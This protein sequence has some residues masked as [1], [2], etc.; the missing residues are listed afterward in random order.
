MTTNL[1]RGNDANLQDLYMDFMRETHDLTPAVG[2]VTGFLSQYGTP[3]EKLDKNAKVARRVEMMFKDGKTAVV[4]HPD[5]NKSVAALTN[6]GA[7]GIRERNR[8][9]MAFTF[10]MLVSRAEIDYRDKKDSGSSYTYLDEMVDLF[11][12]ALEVLKEDQE[13]LFSNGFDG[14]IMFAAAE[15]GAAIAAGATGDLSVAD[16]AIAPQNRLLE[17]VRGGTLVADVQIVTVASPGGAGPAVIQIKNIGTASYTPAQGDE[18]RHLNQGIDGSLFH[19]LDQAFD[20]AAYP[21]EQG[22]NIP[23]SSTNNFPNILSGGNA[24]VNVAQMEKMEMD[25]TRRMNKPRFDRID[26]NRVGLPAGF[27]YIYVGRD[28]MIH[29]LANEFRQAYGRSNATDSSTEL[30]PA[31]VVLIDGKP[32]LKAKTLRNDRFYAL[33]PRD[34]ASLNEV[35]QLLNPNQDRGF[36][37]VPQ[38]V[39]S[40]VIMA[41]H[42]GHFCINRPNQA[43][44]TEVRGNDNTDYGV[45]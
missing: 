15:A 9:R 6:L 19:S 28:E 7:T 37:H 4:G 2:D 29:S 13:I 42:C 18:F 27:G 22:Q 43:R 10:G 8:S 40:E 20:L 14:R 24:R 16:V 31:R 44:I 35:P 26:A 21:R 3:A 41:E 32:Y 11:T 17:V 23:N 30:M 12:D 1:T 38:T 39:K 45:A 34:W 25:I 5:A 36:S 33:S